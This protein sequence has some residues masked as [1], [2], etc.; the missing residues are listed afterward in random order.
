LV[1]L[2]RGWSYVAAPFPIG[3]LTASTIAAEA[4]S[5]NVQEVALL[6]GG[7]YKVWMPSSSQDLPVPAGSAMWVLCQNP[8]TWQPS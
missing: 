1:T 4:S 3:G 5:C 7:S 2:Q 8:A 6:A